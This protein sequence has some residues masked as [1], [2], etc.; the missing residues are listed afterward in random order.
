MR[1][2]GEKT[3]N[4]ADCLGKKDIINN[5]LSYN[6]CGEFWSAKKKGG[7]WKRTRKKGGNLVEER[8]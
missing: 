5:P 1:D 8:G 7:I 6:G 2:G 4:S 3:R